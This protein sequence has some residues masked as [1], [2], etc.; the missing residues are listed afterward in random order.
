[1]KNRT[2][3]LL[4]ALL[5][6]TTAI[7]V[8]AWLIWEDIIPLPFGKLF[9]SY[10][11]QDDFVFRF[12]LVPCFLLQLLLCRA[13]KRVAVRLIPVFLLVGL[14][15]WFSV[16]IFTSTG[17]DGLGW[18][19]LLLLCIAPAAGLVLA[20]IVYGIGALRKWTS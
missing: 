14:V 19:F 15:A 3:Q 13:V 11:S 2:N 6:I 12:H 10:L 20:W 18:A 7:Y 4:L 1:M 8:L 16:G 17:W 9:H 5:I